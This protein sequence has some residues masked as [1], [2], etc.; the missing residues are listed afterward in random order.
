[1]RGDKSVRAPHSS[2]A[3]QRVSKRDM[4]RKASYNHMP[5]DSAVLLVK[6]FNLS[7]LL[8]DLAPSVE[9]IL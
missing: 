5:I 3:V 6:I 2:D 7:R 9:G 8:L 1:M 4:R